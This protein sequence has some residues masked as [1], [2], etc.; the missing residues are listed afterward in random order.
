MKIKAYAVLINGSRIGWFVD[1]VFTNK[2]RAEV[3]ASM[4][5]SKHG[6]TSAR[7]VPCMLTI[8]DAKLQKSVEHWLE[9]NG[10]KGAD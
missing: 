3:W 10:K 2:G 8:Q 9:L 6:K 5:Q 4:P 1:N 7:V